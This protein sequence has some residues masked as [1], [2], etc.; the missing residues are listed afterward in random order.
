[1]NEE[2]DILNNP[3]WFINFY[4]WENDATMLMIKK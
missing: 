3:S 2:F 1:M 4:E